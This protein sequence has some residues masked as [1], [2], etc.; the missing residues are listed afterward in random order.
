[1]R[2]IRYAA[3]G[4]PSVLQLETI[5]TPKPGPGEVLIRVEFAGV[6]PVDSHLRS[7]EHVMKVPLP[8]TPGKDASGHVVEL[9]QNVTSVQI[10]D[11]V[12]VAGHRFQSAGTYA[13]YHVAKE[14]EVFTLPDTYTLEQ[15]ASIGSPY[16]TAIRSLYHA[17]KGKAGEILFIHGAS[18]Q[19]GIAAVQLGVAH[20]FIVYGT[21]GTE[22]GLKRVLDNGAKA[23]FNHRKEGYLEGVKAAIGQ[24]GANIILEMIASTNLQKDFE[25][26]SRRG[27]IVVVGGRGL[28][29][30]NPTLIMAKE[31]IVTGIKLA[32]S[33]PAE[34]KEMS[35][36]LRDGLAK[37]WIKPVISKVCPLADAVQAHQEIEKPTDGAQGRILLRC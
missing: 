18:G 13:E 9:G 16:M 26:A 35:S 37:G 22:E 29:T 7:S 25:L 36:V 28:L 6:N 30:V 5:P 21:A 12:L 27:R 34:W 32:D 15:G 33:E 19:V 10:G 17:A 4:P 14:E 20:G 2:A 3:K 8:A 24:Q 1:M 23:V 31:L 11:R